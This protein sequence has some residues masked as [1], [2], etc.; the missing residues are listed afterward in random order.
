MINGKRVLLGLLGCAAL[1]GCAFSVNSVMRMEEQCRSR[2]PVSAK[3][4][5]Q[6]VSD[7]MRERNR[8]EADKRR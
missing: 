5:Q 8:I 2:Y 7:G 1:T 3:D 6:C 4:Q